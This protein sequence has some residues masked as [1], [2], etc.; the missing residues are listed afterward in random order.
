RPRGGT[1]PHAPSTADPAAPAVH[2]AGHGRPAVHHAGHGAAAR[3]GVRRARTAYDEG[4]ARI[5]P[6]GPFLDEGD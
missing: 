3:H 6:G 2:H 5:A 1:L 4:A